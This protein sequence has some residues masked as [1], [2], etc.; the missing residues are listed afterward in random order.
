VNSRPGTAES[1]DD[2]INAA[3]ANRMNALRIPDDGDATSS[4]APDATDAP[5][6]GAGGDG[7]VSEGLARHSCA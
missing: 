6:T 7:R 4:S 3:L 1:D 2:D 5:L